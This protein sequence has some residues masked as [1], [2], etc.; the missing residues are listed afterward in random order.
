MAELA[1]QRIE[2]AICAV[3]F[4]HMVAGAYSAPTPSLSNL[5]DFVCSSPR[6][7]VNALRVEP[8]LELV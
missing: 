8:R 6:P 1:Y 2:A 5:E 4:R 7:V 3:V